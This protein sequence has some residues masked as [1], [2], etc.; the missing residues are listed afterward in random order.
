MYSCP[1]C[2]SDNT[3]L[4]GKN[5]SGNQMILCKSC[6]KQRT[7]QLKP[8]QPPICKCCGKKDGLIYKRVSLC[9]KCYVSYRRK[10]DTTKMKLV[11]SI[12]THF[13]DVKQ[14]SR[15]AENIV[16]NGINIKTLSPAEIINLDKEINDSSSRLINNSV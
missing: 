8:N 12:A 15:I 1:N 4:A 3:V 11:Q 6:F 16:E 14:W 10:V 9:K 5:K 2:G 13:T 7:V